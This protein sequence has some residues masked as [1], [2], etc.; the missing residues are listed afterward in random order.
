MPTMRGNTSIA[1]T[2][3]NTN[4]LADQDYEFIASRAIVSILCAQS[5]IGLEVGFKVGTNEIVSAATPNVA[6]AANRLVE[7]DDRLLDKT[8]IP[9]G[10]LKLEARNA[11]GG[12]LTLHWLVEIENVPQ[13]L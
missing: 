1:A 4:L 6:V 2:S 10:R 11:T 9:P 8:I 3:V 5:A 12:A 7:P 13:G